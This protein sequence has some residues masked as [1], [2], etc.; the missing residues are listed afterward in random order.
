MTL[1]SSKPHISKALIIT[2]FLCVPL[3]H[4]PFSFAQ[5][6]DIQIVKSKKNI[7]AWL[8][9]DHSLPIIQM[10]FRW[11]AGASYGQKS[12]GVYLMSK[13]LT[14]GAGNLDEEAFRNALESKAVSLS[15]G[16]D[17]DHITGY[18][19]TLTQY[20]TD[21]FKLL[22]LAIYEPQFSKDTFNALRKQTLPNFTYQEGNA[23]SIGGK[24][25]REAYFG[26]HPYAQSTIGTRESLENITIEDIKNMYQNHLA[27]DNLIVSVVGDIT[28]EDLAILLDDIF[29]KLPEKANIP[30]LPKAK[31]KQGFTTSLIKRN[32]KQTAVFWIR[33]GIGLADP[34]YHKAVIANYALSGH[35]LSRLGGTLREERGLTYAVWSYN[36]PRDLGAVWRGQFETRNDK[37]VEAIQLA[38]AEMEKMGQKNIDDKTLANAKSH[39]I[40]SSVV[41][42]ATGAQILSYLTRSQTRN[43]PTN[44][45]DILKE[46]INEVTADDVRHISKRLFDKDNLIIVAVGNPDNWPPRLDGKIDKADEDGSHKSKKS[47]DS[48]KKPKKPFWDIF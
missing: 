4:M 40:G 1:F 47:K 34:D 35:R 14:R 25:L 46:K 44:Y 22:K 23:S 11:R 43:R 2:I 45:L 36:D 24:H 9:E 33:E 17:H 27:L 32:N 12:G 7:T 29:G 42:L 13:L 28:K 18:I 26:L 37:T 10:E 6:L 48:S 3:T 8:V 5:K 20:K 38:R 39:I 21:A 31:P 19:K 15:V 30:T 16:T 41:R